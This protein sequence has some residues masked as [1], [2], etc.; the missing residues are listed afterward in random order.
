MMRRRPC[1]LVLAAIVCASLLACGG[2]EPS[3]ALDA[4]AWASPVIEQGLTDRDPWIRAETVRLVGLLQDRRWAARLR[5]TLTD[6]SPLVQNAAVEA[7]LKLGDDQAENATLNLLVS[8]TTEQRAQLVDLVAGAAEGDFRRQAIERSLRDTAPAVRAAA[9][10]AIAAHNVRVSLDTL[11]HL[12][13]DAD[14]RV[15]D[16][17]FTWL[18][19]QQPDRARDAAMQ[20][21]RSDEP[22]TRQRGIALARHLAS[23]DLWPAMRSYAVSGSESDQRMAVLFLGRLGDPLAEE[24]LRQL[25]LSADSQTAA[26]ALDSLSYIDTPRA[27]EQARRHRNDARMPVRAAAFDVML[28][29]GAPNELLEGFLGDT[30][31]ELAY[32]ALIGLQRRDATFTAGAI[33]RSL[34]DAEEPASPLR[35]LVRS[36]MRADIRPMLRQ[37]RETLLPLTTHE[38]PDVTWMATRLVLQVDTPAGHTERILRDGRAEPVYALLE[39]S[40]TDGENHSSL[41]T[42]TMDDDLF[43]VRLATAV[44]MWKLDANYVAPQPEPGAS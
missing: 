29:Q 7:L 30:D 4:R 21:L 3:Q 41:Y 10:R 34:R 5:D 8:G 37:A 11:D 2:D 13:D 20:R 24:P 33:A 22:A 25:V 32:R 18:A 17:A 44:G 43:L 28:R 35:A 6:P 31:P 14:V 26:F 38:D 40:L 36:S 9:V 39:R 27:Q 42:E 12:V 1:V 23:A 15:A 19:T 16:E